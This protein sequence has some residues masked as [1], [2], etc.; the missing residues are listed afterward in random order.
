MFLDT[1]ES[2]TLD[3]NPRP[4]RSRFLVAMPQTLEFIHTCQIDG[5]MISI[6][7]RLIRIRDTDSTL[8]ITINLTPWYP[9]SKFSF[10]PLVHGHPHRKQIQTNMI[11]EQKVQ[12]DFGF[13]RSISTSK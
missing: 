2:S 8:N 4:N 11:Q 10:G 1:L 9:T 3:P 7:E 12:W 6:Q 5:W 13:A